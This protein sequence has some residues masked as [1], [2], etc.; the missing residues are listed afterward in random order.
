MLALAVLSCMLLVVAPACIYKKDRSKAPPPHAKKHDNA[1]KKQT[2]P[3]TKMKKVAQ[4]K[5]ADVQKK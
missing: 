4:S 2:K 3:D 1:T 5:R